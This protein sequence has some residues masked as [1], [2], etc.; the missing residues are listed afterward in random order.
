MKLFST[1]KLDEGALPVTED[2]AAVRRP[3]LALGMVHGFLRHILQ[4]VEAD[5]EPWQR[6][7]ALTPRGA[8]FDL[9]DM[10]DGSTVLDKLAMTSDAMGEAIARN[11]PPGEV[12]QGVLPHLATPMGALVERREAVK[13]DAK[14]NVFLKRYA[15]VLNRLEDDVHSIGRSMGDLSGIVARGAAGLDPDATRRTISRMRQLGDAAMRLIEDRIAS[16]GNREEGKRLRALRDDLKAWIEERNAR[17]E[18]MQTAADELSIRSNALRN[19]CVMQA[20]RLAAAAALAGQTGAGAGLPSPLSGAEQASP[21]ALVLSAT[22][23]ALML[24][25][26]TDVTAALRE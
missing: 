1:N 21:E 4:S 11:D 13:S 12:G 26:R 22:L 3:D 25:S 17:L 18:Q 5:A 6:Q 2:A 15:P 7:L 8:D 14:Q 10:G 20:K 23:R 19:E 16:A 24:E 9:R